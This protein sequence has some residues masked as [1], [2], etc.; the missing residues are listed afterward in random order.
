MP[1]WGSFHQR[2]NLVSLNC[3]DQGNWSLGRKKRTKVWRRWDRNSQFYPPQ[4]RGQRFG[5][6]EGR[7]KINNSSSSSERE[8]VVGVVGWW[9]QKHAMKRGG[10]W[11]TRL[12]LGTSR[13]HGLAKRRKKKAEP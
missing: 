7:K 6:H 10:E 2:E 12:A 9:A 1:L 11:E 3:L 13:R 5:Y 4:S 8:K